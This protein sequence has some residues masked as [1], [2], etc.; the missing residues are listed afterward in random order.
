MYKYYTHL[1]S[2]GESLY[3]AVFLPEKDGKFP[4][5]IIRNCYIDHL[6]D[7]TD[8]EVLEQYGES[9]FV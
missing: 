9:D 4:T 8:D 2:E 1:E 6:I 3:T 7:L 5:V